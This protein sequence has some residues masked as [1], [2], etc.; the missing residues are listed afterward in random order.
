MQK[1]KITRLAAYFAV[2]LGVAA[3]GADGDDGSDN[4][5]DGG[6]TSGDQILDETQ[7]QLSGIL[8][9]LGNQLLVID[10]SSPLKV[11][12]FVKCLDPT[13]NQLLDGPDGLLTGLLQTVNGGVTGGVNN[14]SSAL[15]PELLQD[16]IV[17][18]AGGLQSLTETL[19]RALLALANQGSCTG[20]SAPGGSNPLAMLTLLAGQSNGPL[21][22]L[23]DAL[24]AAGVPANGGGDG[25]TGTPLDILL[26]PLTDLAAG[27]S[28]SS[29]GNLADVVNLLGGGVQ[30]LGGAL[31]QNLSAQTQAVPVVG[32]V[33]ELLGDALTNVGAVLTD[34]DNG[35][36]TNQQLLGTV[37]SLLSDLLLTLAVIPGSSTLVTPLQGA[38]N[39]ATGGLNAIT[40]PLTQLLA[41]IT[42]LPGGGTAGGNL[43]TGSIPVLGDLLDSLLG[44]LTGLGGLSGGLTGGTTG[45]TSG[46]STGGSTTPDPLEVLES[47]PV[48]GPILGGLLGGLGGLI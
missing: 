45:G 15:N 39:Q 37:N 42:A 5:T 36:T 34:L 14:V 48:I 9:G 44:G 29:I 27:G 33:V 21:K 16:G 18:L 23:M 8:S 7:D 28:G 1:F 24:L 41:T 31:T 25:P 38:I 19:P 26:G 40:T 22:P 13:L 43:P 47:I 35:T 6:N 46:G 4:G 12:A 10:N 3:C 20:S 32:G 11:G 17:D 30:T 2:A